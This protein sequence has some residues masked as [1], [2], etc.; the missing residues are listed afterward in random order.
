MKKTRL[1]LLFVGLFSLMSLTGCSNDDESN[2]EN[3]MELALC[4]SWVLVS[5]GDESNEV[6]K[7]AEGYHYEIIF[8]PNGIYSGYAYGNK[9]EGKY[10]CSGNKISIS[11]PSI[12]KVYYEGSD[13]DEFF[14]DQLNSVNTFTVTATELRLYYSKNQYF[15]FR[16]K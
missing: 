3:N 11:Y 13:P 12:T 15:K 9:M 16:L 1:L 14:L 10:K 4:D 2:N 5:Y 7:E 6:L 8:Y